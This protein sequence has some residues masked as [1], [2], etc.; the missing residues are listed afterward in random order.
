MTLAELA[1]LLDKQKRRQ[2]LDTTDLD[3][4]DTVSNTPVVMLTSRSSLAA[5][6][7]G[8]R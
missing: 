3:E 4:N 5:R 6:M 8:R 1:S 2:V 7:L